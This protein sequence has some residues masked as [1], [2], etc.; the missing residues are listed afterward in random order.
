MEH[1]GT[2]FSGGKP[3]PFILTLPDNMQ[4]EQKI[5]AVVLCHGHSRYNGDGLDNL[6]K[7]LEESGIASLRFNFSGCGVTSVRRYHLYCSTEWTQDLSCALSFLK[8]FP[9]IDLERIGT[10]GISMGACTVLFNAGEEQ[11]VKSVVSMAGITDCGSWLEGVWE[12]SGGDWTSFR[13]TLET[14]HALAAATG[15]SQLVNVL[16]MYNETAEA[17]AAVV[18]ESL[19]EPDINA[20]VSMDSLFH[21]VNYRPIEKCAKVVCSALILHGSSDTLVPVEN[22]QALFEAIPAAH[23]QLKIYDGVDHNIP[24]NALSDMVFKD[25][26]TWFAN[27]L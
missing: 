18:Q 14:E 3:L 15:K 7:R 1:D 4:A 12:R 9:Q 24:R 16:E 19:E 6:A 13:H 17:K 21:L 26:A 27:S 25:I 20:Y 11:R 10:A 5:P 23:K 22:A 2:F 8:K